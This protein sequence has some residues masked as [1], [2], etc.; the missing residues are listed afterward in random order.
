MSVRI[1]SLDKWFGNEL[2][3]NVKSDTSGKGDYA[4][5]VLN[6]KVDAFLDSEAGAGDITI[7]TELVGEVGKF[8]TSLAK[9]IENEKGEDDE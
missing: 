2:H 8:L 4:E 7:P 3:I 6:L 9:Y 1:E 5:D